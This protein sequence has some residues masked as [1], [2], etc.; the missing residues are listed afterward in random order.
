LDLNNDEDDFLAEI[1]PVLEDYHSHN[2]FRL[3]FKGMQQLLLKIDLVREDLQQFEKEKEEEKKKM[4]EL[5]NK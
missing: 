5:I 3:D 4:H 2:T 1:E